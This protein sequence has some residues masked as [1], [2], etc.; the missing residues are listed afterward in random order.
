MLAELTA[1]CSNYTSRKLIYVIV[2]NTGLM[3]PVN[4]E[5]FSK[6]VSCE[7][8]QV[9]QDKHDLAALYFFNNNVPL[10]SKMQHAVSVIG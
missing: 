10:F 9:Y 7:G 6:R 4:Q 5:A 1:P 3:I 2:F 8:H